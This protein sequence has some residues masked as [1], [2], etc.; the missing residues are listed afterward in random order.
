M[1]DSWVFQTDI[2]FGIG[3]APN[4]NDEE[5]TKGAYSSDQ[6]RSERP[7]LS[8]AVGDAGPSPK[9]LGRAA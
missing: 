7:M 5:T 6:F 4:L 1:M 2:E 9:R 3:V 8:G